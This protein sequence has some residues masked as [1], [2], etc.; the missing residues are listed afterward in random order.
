MVGHRVCLYAPRSGLRFSGL[1]D[2]T[3]LIR[4]WNGGRLTRA[5][6]YA[7]GYRLPLVQ[8]KI[9]LRICRRDILS[10]ELGPEHDVG[11]R[12]DF[13]YWKHKP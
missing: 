3:S 1:T 6:E 8:F 12:T 5:A 2:K 7:D 4:R 11:V 10:A 9:R 13:D